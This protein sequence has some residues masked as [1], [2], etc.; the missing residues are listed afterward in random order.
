[1]QA[2]AARA[3]GVRT[4]GSRMLY[5]GKSGISFAKV[6]LPTRCVSGA[7][8]RRVSRRRGSPTTE[9]RCFRGE[10]T[11]ATRRSA[12]SRRLENWSALRAKFRRRRLECR[13]FSPT[14]R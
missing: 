14:F 9:G 5:P 13:L 4:L 3:R 10:K 6:I 1:M 11:D 8:R 7:S 2:A 12:I